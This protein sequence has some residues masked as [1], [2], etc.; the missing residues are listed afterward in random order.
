MHGPF[1]VAAVQ[2]APEFLDLDAGIDKAVK[3]IED[4]A[5]RGF[6]G[7]N[8]TVVHRVPAREG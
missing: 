4:A 5:A 7:A 8:L 1:K 2:A 3:L 6:G